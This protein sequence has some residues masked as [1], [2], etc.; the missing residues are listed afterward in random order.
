MRVPVVAL[1]SS[2][3]PLRVSATPSRTGL[4]PPPSARSAAPALHAPDG[5]LEIRAVHTTTPIVVDGVLDDPVWRKAPVVSHFVQSEPHEGRPAT[6]RTDVQVAFDAHNLYI[7]A[8]CHDT[9]PAGIV[10]NDVKRD[11]TPGDQDDFEVILDTFAD[12]RNGY[13]FITNAGGAKSDE[14]FSNE[15]RDINT[16]WD[17]V[18]HVRTR[19]VADGWTV[20]MAIPFHSLRFNRA[21]NDLWGINFG[22]RNPSQ[23]RARLLGADPPV[24]R[25]DPRVAGRRPRRPDD[26]PSGTRSED[27]AVRAGQSPCVPSAARR[28]IER[29]MP[30]SI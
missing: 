18:W 22:R 5:R 23:E 13:A 17:A 28:S 14:Q 27:H 9:D 25:P 6:E 11:F 29:P 20:E 26:G 8:Y 19:R 30:A 4:H 7:A 10:L 3:R 21:R 12:R 15:G 24:V 2:S 1:A 16:S